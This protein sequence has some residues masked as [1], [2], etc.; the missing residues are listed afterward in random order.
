MNKAI[1][2]LASDVCDHSIV[3]LKKF[4]PKRVLC[5][6]SRYCATAKQQSTMLMIFEKLSEQVPN[7]L[8]PDSLTDLLYSF[9][10]VCQ[11]GR[12]LLP[13]VT[14]FQ[15]NTLEVLGIYSTSFNSSFIC[16]MGNII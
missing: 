3:V 9:Q 1:F 4:G 15:C 10:N 11:V 2:E 14:N 5:D 8:H 6:C 12:Y 7:S 13:A 16:L